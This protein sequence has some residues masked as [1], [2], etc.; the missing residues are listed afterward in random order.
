MKTVMPFPGELV[1]QY[2]V[3][4]TVNG[5]IFIPDNTHETPM[6][7]VVLRIGDKVWDV[8]V[9]DRVLVTPFAGDTVIIG[10]CKYQIIKAGDVQ[11]VIEDTTEAETEDQTK[12]AQREE[13]IGVAKKSTKKGGK[14][15]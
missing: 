3:R 13:V 5:T 10:D 9:G 1:V 8:K 7:A 14:K 6:E 11:G 15:C 2:A 4:K 12:A